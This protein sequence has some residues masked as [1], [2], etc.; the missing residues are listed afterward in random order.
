MLK[1]NGVNPDDFTD[2]YIARAVGLVKSR[3][4]FVADLWEQARFFFKAPEEYAEKD[5]RKRWKEDTPEILTALIAL[6]RDLPDFSA[7]AAEPVVLQWVNDNGYHL[8]NV[9]NAFRLCLVGECKG[10][11]IFDITELIGR[12]ETIARIERGIERIG[13]TGE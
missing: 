10:P 7:A 11:H 5:I 9:M 1:A 2:N 3:I 4:N 13:K 8:G 6:L 12:D